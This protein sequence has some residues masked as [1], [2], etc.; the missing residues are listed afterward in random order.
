VPNIS[1]AK[2]LDVPF[3]P[4]VYFFIFLAANILLSYFPFP[5]QVQLG[6]CFLG[7]LV[8][9]TLAW[10]TYVPPSPHKPLFLQEFFPSIPVWAWVG[11]ASLAV[12][13]RLYRLTSLFVWPHGDEGLYGF[14]ALQI[15]RNGIDRLLY[16]RAQHPPFYFW[17]LSL[18]FRLGGPSIRSLWFSPL[19]FSLGL[20]PMVYAVCR[21]WDFSKSFSFLCAL[22]AAISFWFWFIGRFAMNTCLIPLME[23][24]VFG[25]CGILFRAQRDRQQWT[26]ALILG[27]S[28]GLTFYA[29]YL[30]W[31]ALALLVGLTVLG[32]F[33]RSS[34]VILIFG[35]ATLLAVLPFLFHIRESGLSPYFQ[36]LWSFKDHAFSWARVEEAFS[37]WSAVFWG[38]PISYYTYQPVWGGFLNPVLGAFF[39]LG[40]L[41]A[42]RGSH[43]LGRWLAGAFLFLLLPGMLSRD[44]ETFRIAPDAVITLPLVALG[45]G[46]LAVSKFRFR[47]PWRWL[48]A[49]LAL[50][51]LLDFYHLAGPLHHVWD[52]PGYWLKFTKSIN[53]YRAYNILEARSQDQ[54][55][56]LILS[57]FPAGTCDQTLDTADYGFNSASNPALDADKAR[58]VAVLANVNDQP[59]LVK[60]F[61]AGKSYWLSKDLHSPDGGFML[62][63]API[64]AANRA[65]FLRWTG[66]HRALDGFID[67]YLQN[68]SY[69]GGGFFGKVRDSLRQTHGYFQGDSFLEACYWEKMA[70]LSIKEGRLPDAVENLQQAVHLGC[71]SAHLFYRLGVLQLALN[72]P[73][74]AR[75]CFQEAVRAPLDFTESRLLLAQLSP[76]APVERKP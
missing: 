53:N 23:T 19:L 47:R 4:W 37:Y 39:G 3:H 17:W 56:G 71:P 22:L 69:N 76:T 5:L 72:D 57:N 68:L 67:S 8:P 59:F 55:P 7:I 24:F 41:E 70:D 73:P 58:W 49:A 65:V 16:C 27:L 40:F 12:L 46:R 21:R 48:G 42:A 31:V 26:A 50:S 35:S 1:A 6:V 32:A 36:G 75:K 13:P 14:Y 2:A 33:R 25:C 52:D 63:I 44:S 34:L 15:M 30:H 66:A 45:I 20:P 29:L 54:G 18:C 64:T 28:V 38:L 11:M 60:R 61:G 74:Q 10:K 9:F 62:W 51:F 43:P